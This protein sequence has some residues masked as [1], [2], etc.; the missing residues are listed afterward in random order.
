VFAVGVESL[1]WV[2]GSGCVLFVGQIG[3]GLGE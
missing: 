1:V 3:V 2:W